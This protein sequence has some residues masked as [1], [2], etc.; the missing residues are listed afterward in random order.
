[1]GAEEAAA[2]S[3]GSSL[4]MMIAVAVVAITVVLF[5]VFRKKA[6]TPDAALLLGLQDS[7]KTAVYTRLRYGDE[8]PLKDTVTS[9]DVN[10]GPLTDESTS[11]SVHR[12]CDLPPETATEQEC[13]ASE[14]GMAAGELA[15]WCGESRGPLVALS[16]HLSVAVRQLALAALLQDRLAEDSPAAEDGVKLL[17]VLPAVAAAAT[18]LVRAAVQFLRL[19]ACVCVCVCVG[20]VVGAVQIAR[21]REQTGLPLGD[22][23]PLTARGCGGLGFRGGAG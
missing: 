10:E 17:D 1:M 14:D 2:A 23:Q 9:I 19:R 16:D 6:P 5:L 8:I 13:A 4:P 15:A 12:L 22:I 11:K 18:K 3:G 21:A 7:G 20:G